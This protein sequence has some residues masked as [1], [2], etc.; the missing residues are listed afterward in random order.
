MKTKYLD[1]K[2][3]RRI[4]HSDYEEILTKYDGQSV[5]IGCFYIK[6]VYH[7][8]I[9]NI[10]GEKVKV[11]DNNYKWITMMGEDENFSLTVMFDDN[12]QPLQYYFD[13]NK[14]H[15]LELGHAR[16]EDMYLDVLALPDGRSE[17]VD[18]DDVIRAL[19]QGK[20]TPE[21]RDFAYKIAYDLENLIQ[22]Q[23]DKVVNR[24]KF[25]YQAIME[26]KQ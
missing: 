25:M 7:P 23:F 24:G 12:D 9:I 20:M 3:W 18:E 8:L 13:I 21:E 4:K 14:S 11:V 1:K 22:F 15:T 10:V 19:K 5:L 16:R 2:N 26:R 17:I 6:K